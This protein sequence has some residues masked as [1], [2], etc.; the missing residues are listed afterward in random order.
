MSLADY[1]LFVAGF[2]LVHGLAYTLAGVVDLQIADFVYRG[3]DRHVDFLRDVND[4]DERSHVSRTFL[5]AQILRGALMAIVLLP[6]LGP[7]G[8]LDPVVRV[9][10]LGGL[11]F[12]YADLASAVPFPNTI[13][14][15]VYLRA[16]YLSRDAFLAIQ[17]E[18][19]VYS[20]LFAVPAALLLF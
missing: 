19:L 5:P 7:I 13:E 6:L 8:D 3:Q 15:L 16:E 14:G 10:F 17:F 9:A 20:V 4:P 12:V 18:A 11:M 2:T 1:G